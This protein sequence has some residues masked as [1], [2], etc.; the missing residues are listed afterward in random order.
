MAIE[1]L[2]VAED[3]ICSHFLQIPMQMHIHSIDI[4]SM[5]VHE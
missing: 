2:R 3:V 5:K 1:K 4:S